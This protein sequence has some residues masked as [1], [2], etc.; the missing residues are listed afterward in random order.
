MIYVTI[1]VLFITGE[2][3]RSFMAEIVF[4]FFFLPLKQVSKIRLVGENLGYHLEWLGD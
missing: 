4:F 1:F 2:I 3:R